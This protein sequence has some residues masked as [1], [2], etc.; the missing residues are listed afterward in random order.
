MEWR[1]RALR[2]LPLCLV[3]CVLFFVIMFLRYKAFPTLDRLPYSK[4]STCPAVAP[5]RTA[6]LV[7]YIPSPIAW[8]ERRQRVLRQMRRELGNSTH[9]FFV[10]GTL[11]GPLLERNVTLA[12]GEKEAAAERDG[13][14]RYLFT[15]CRDI[16]DE[17][18]NA[19]GTSS[20][21]CKDYQALVHIAHAYADSPPRFVW[22]GADDAYLDLNVFRRFVA[23]ALQTCRLFFGYLEFPGPF[24]R[25]DLDIYSN[26]P[27]L[28]ALLGLKKFGKYM[29]GMGF[30]MSWD[31]VQF[32][33]LAPIPPRL[34]YPEDVVVSQ[35]LLF[36][37]IDW[38]DFHDVGQVGMHNLDHSPTL[39][40]L[41][42]QMH[43][44][45]SYK[46]LVGH[47]MSDTQWDA[48]YA[49]PLDDHSIH[50]ALV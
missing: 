5:G 19:N 24:Q 18:D 25:I 32:I 12:A 46:V 9:V 16:G 11:D 49:R 20:T 27:R 26:Q 31:V 3:A 35:W 37:D 29:Y 15:P 47:K 43:N 33:G 41:Q 7:V 34:I 8:H 40:W 50:F 10:F 2:F 14:V 39:A 1:A 36:H 42:K 48:L 23:P 38:V 44:N 4:R 21:T 22:R 28:Y 45:P 6:D 13:R 30:C 17:R